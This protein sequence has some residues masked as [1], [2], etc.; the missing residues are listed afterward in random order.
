MEA[1]PIYEGEKP[2]LFISY[3]H[4]NSPAVMQ[5]VEELAEAGY[6]VWYDD[7]I[8]VGSEWP[9]T[10]AAH[11]AA[12]DCMV[13]FVSNAYMRSDNC[14]K[15]MHFALSKKIPVIN[16][17]LEQ[18]ALSPGME[19]QIGNIFALM[20]YTMRDEIF[21]EK[22][23]AA[24]QL[25]DELRES[26]QGKQKRRIRHKK[27]TVDLDAEA[28]RKRR[29][30][31]R[32]LAAALLLL[33]LLIAGAILGTVGWKTGFLQRLLLRH[34]QAEIDVLPP[35]TEAVFHSA[36]LEKKARDYSGVS[37]GS[38]RVADLTA[39]GELTLRG[40]EIDETA[41]A[42]LRYFPDL[43]MLTLEDAPLSSLRAL[44]ESG[45]E[46]LVLRGGKLTTLDGIG[47][48]PRLQSLRADEV[49]LR[50]LGDLS[51]CLELRTL[52]L[53]GGTVHDFSA[54]RP[55]R[56]LA[57]AELA[58]CTLSELR[59]LL[60]NSALSDL[61]LTDC[62][63]RGGFF[64]AFDRESAIIRLSL[65]DCLLDSTDNLE[66]FSG[67]TTLRLI[68]SG[69]TLDYSALAGIKALRLVQADESM[70]AVLQQ[71]LEGSEV[72]LEIIE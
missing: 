68:H 25:S 50:E 56:R 1:V 6:R 20:K 17:F 39:L 18:T 11:L 22:L 53:S 42:E 46:A 57:E 5:V 2:Y 45:I 10:I 31:K 59:P 54:L 23:F 8:E 60:R 37:E 16:I 3:A 33:V 14:R 41:L 51:R 21:Y 7:G 49:P 71:A 44:S 63:L 40:D 19:M 70:R 62:D 27:V 13:A 38:L 32:R 61:T 30:K 29:R 52:S 24:P 34:E 55:L 43:Q 48:L 58:G 4:S 12:A 28:K 69:E 65:S 36:A 35:D 64:R 15:E 72:K 66:D 26:G 47:N 9:E 67:L